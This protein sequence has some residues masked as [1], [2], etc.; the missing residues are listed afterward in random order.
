M[1]NAKVKTNKLPESFKPFLWSYDFEKLDL[2]KNKK[3]II[4]NLLNFGTKECTD[5]LLKLYDRAEIKTAIR[6]SYESEWDKKSLNYWSYI[7]SVKP[8][9]KKRVVI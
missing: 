3:I 1:K 9:D 5:E 6:N 2:I 7:F 8:K 4:L